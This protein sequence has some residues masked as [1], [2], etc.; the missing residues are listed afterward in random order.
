LKFTR[1]GRILYRSVDNLQ[2]FW[3]APSLF[4]EASFQRVLKVYKGFPGGFQ[5]ISEGFKGF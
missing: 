5:R 2:M 4:W 1:P 3:S